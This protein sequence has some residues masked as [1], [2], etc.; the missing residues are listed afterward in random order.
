MLPSSPLHA[1]W[2]VLKDSSC[3]STQPVGTPSCADLCRLPARLCAGGEGGACL[4]A[5][6]RKARLGC[7]ILAQVFFRLGSGLLCLLGL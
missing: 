7:S 4:Q 2:V 1:G 3:G 6:S 5:S